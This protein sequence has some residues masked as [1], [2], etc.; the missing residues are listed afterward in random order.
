MNIF[1][2]FNRKEGKAG[3]STFISEAASGNSAEEAPATTTYKDSKRVHNLILVDE[4]GSMYSI[5]NAALTGI[6]ETLQTIRE[7]NVENKGQEHLVTLI[8]F[9]TGHYNAIYQD[10]PAGKTVDITS[11]QYNPNGGTPLYDAMGRSI[12]ELRNKVGEGDVVLMTIITD[13][14]ENAS[15]EYNGPAIKKLVEEMK[16]ENWVFT[17]IGANQD[18]TAVAQSMAIDHSMEFKAD[19][20]GA[21]MMFQ[22][23]SRSRKRFF[24][25]LQAPAPMSK[26][27]KEKFFDEDA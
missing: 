16:K 1:K 14:Y 26:I 24:S 5:Y 18:V 8:T 11:E 19:P 3:E 2:F 21:S 4:S 7:A 27:M 12:N 23:E 13:G 15:R 20:V 10:T 22:K 9:D 17:Y 25:R 6:N